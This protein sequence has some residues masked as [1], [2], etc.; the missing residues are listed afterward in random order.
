MRFDTR[1]V[2]AGQ[3]PTPGSADLVPPIH[4]ATVYDRF[5]QPDR[6]YFYGRGENPTREALEECLAALEEVPYATTFASGQA[7]AAAVLSLLT[8]GQTLVCSDDVYGGT[9]ALFDAAARSGVRVTPWDLSLPDAGERLG[10]AAMVWVES[11]TNPLLKVTDLAAAARAAHDRGALLVVDN[12]L[13]GPALQ[14][15]ATLGADIVLHSTSKSL[16]GHLDVIGGA[17]A[18]HD[19]DLH[20]RLRDY[21]T[22][23][24]NVPS[25]FD[26]H[27]IHRGLKTLALRVARQCDSARLLAEA[28]QDEPSV[29]ALRYPGL[30]SHP[31]HRVAER[32]M[33]RP[34]SLLS[35]VYAGD[36]EALMR[37]VRL[38]APAVSLG[39][40]RSLI[41]CPA[42]MTHRPV[43]RPTRLRLG[44]DD[45]LIRVSAGIEDPD[46]LVGDLLAAVRAGGS[47]AR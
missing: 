15:P 19:P 5:G 14:Q 39:G 30:A 43:P 10:D 22:T 26:C 18:Y 2:H 36:P 28:L 33:R 17:L 20:A 16:A 4:V 27:Q 31:Q 40:V 1:L 12:T 41:E 11:P 6:R 35:F 13:A 42:L 9:H 44:I 29:S 21:R 37:R 24:G 23:F 3:P 25:P 8:P 47:A 32:Q 34:G 45:H 46:D 7:A 38:F